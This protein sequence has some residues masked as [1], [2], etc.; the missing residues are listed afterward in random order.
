M[1]ATLLESQPMLSEQTFCAC[2]DGIRIRTALRELM[3]LDLEET[4]EYSDRSD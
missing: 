1:E 2:C 3:V 4:V